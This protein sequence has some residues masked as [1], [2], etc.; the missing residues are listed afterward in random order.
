[1]IK[2]FRDFSFK[3]KLILIVMLTSCIVVLIAS[4]LYI[5]NDFIT[6]RSTMTLVKIVRH[7]WHSMIIIQPRKSS[8]D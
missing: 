6:L 3:N 5:I 7:H 8:P 2:K 1:M 4:S